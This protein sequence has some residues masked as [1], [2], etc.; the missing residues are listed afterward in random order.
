[1]K[2]VQRALMIQAWCFTSAIIAGWLAAKPLKAEL[3]RMKEEWEA[4]LHFPAG[5]GLSQARSSRV[6]S[7]MTSQVRI[8]TTQ[9]FERALLRTKFHD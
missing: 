8:A 9:A 4:A 6:I 5:S 7:G 3:R 1:M 2:A